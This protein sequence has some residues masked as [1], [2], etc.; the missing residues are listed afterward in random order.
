MDLLKITN[1]TDHPDNPD[2][3]GS[4]AHILEIYGVQV[5]PGQTIQI[6]SELIND[7][8]INL[9][10][11]RYICIGGWPDYYKKFKNPPYVPEAPSQPTNQTNGEDVS[12]TQSTEVILPETKVEGLFSFNAKKKSK[13][14]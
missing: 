2:G 6:E 13:D 1:I 8:I 12:S 4:L 11:N 5:M 14:K 7:K 10:E 9:Q 3:E